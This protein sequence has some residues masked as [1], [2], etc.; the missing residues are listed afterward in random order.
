MSFVL[1][2]VTGI[3]LALMLATAASTWWFSTGIVAPAVGTV[4][5]IVIAAIKVWFVMA[6]FMELRNAPLPWKLA[7]MTWLA[8]TASVILIVYLT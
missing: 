8:A 2:P 3:W 1:K 6:H 5:V 4:A 7:G